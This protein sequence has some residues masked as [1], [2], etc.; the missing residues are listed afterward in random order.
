LYFVIVKHY[1]FGH[2]LP[3]RVYEADGVFYTWLVNNLQ[4]LPTNFAVVSTVIAQLLLLVQAFALN[5]FFNSFKLFN[6][7]SYVPAAIFLLITSFVE[8]WNTLS[9]ALIASTIF[10]IAFVQL[11]KLATAQS[12][13][14]LLYN[15]CFF[16]GIAQL[17]Y[18]YSASL[19][20]VVLGIYIVNRSFN[21]KEFL[22]C[23][24]GLLTPIYM[25]TSVQ[26]LTNRLNWASSVPKIKFILPNL[27]H[28]QALLIAF[29]VLAALCAI[30][31]VTFI[32]QSNRLVVQVRNIWKLFIL[33]L[34][35]TALTPLLY[36]SVGY[37]SL[38]ALPL[39]A[40]CS[41]VFFTK[42]NTRLK[43]VLHWLLLFGVLLVQYMVF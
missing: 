31:I 15:I 26:Y 5:R 4:K 11:A 40:F 22:V 9:A 25:L 13:K 8:E 27:E 24:I 12:P 6:K 38:C 16:V 18:M 37:W 23:I 35:V 10:F 36:P 29:I 41:I 3:A 21:A 20:L 42:K 30:G 7:A 19:L 2:C 17:F 28:A 1:F 32:G 39:G 33:Y 34:I 14:I 43:N